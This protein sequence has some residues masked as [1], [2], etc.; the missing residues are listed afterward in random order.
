MFT[1]LLPSNRF[2]MDNGTQFLPSNRFAV[3]MSVSD[4][5]VYLFIDIAFT[6]HSHM[7]FSLGFVGSVALT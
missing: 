3:V 4:E 5:P 7:S 2:A 6:Y 1:Q